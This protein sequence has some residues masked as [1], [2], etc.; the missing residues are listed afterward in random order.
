MSG[1]VANWNW[2]KNIPGIMGDM[3]E[4][5]GESGGD[6]EVLHHY[7]ES[8]KQ[9]TAHGLAMMFA[10]GTAPQAQTS[11][12][13]MQGHC[14]GSQ[15]EKTP[16]I[17]EAYA[18]P[19]RQAGVHTS[20]RRYMSSLARFPGDPEAWVDSLDEGKKLC[21]KRGWGMTDGNERELVKMRQPEKERVPVEVADD[22]LEEQAN[23]EIAAAPKGSLKESKREIKERIKDKIK[24]KKS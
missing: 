7:L 14:N 11:R 8:R 16:H 20:G 18:R 4:V 1:I 15:F 23:L 22:I 12:E 9:G 21:E 2:L 13:F 10:L 5:V 24:R 17:G 19:A 3:A 6:Q